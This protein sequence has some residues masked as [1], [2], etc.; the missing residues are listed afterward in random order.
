MILHV[1]SLIGIYPAR[2]FLWTLTYPDFTQRQGEFV[3]HFPVSLVE[4]ESALKEI[5][6]V[7]E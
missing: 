4:A 6:E 3:F 5:L 7:V 1:T 2:L